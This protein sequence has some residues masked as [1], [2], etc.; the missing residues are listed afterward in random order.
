M[1]LE[2]YWLKMT[3]HHLPISAQL[4]WLIR[5]SVPCSLNL[6]IFIFITSHFY[7]F[8]VFHCHAAFHSALWRSFSLGPLTH[9]FHSALWRSFSTRPFVFHFCHQNHH[10]LIPQTKVIIL[11]SL[12]HCV[13]FWPNGS[14]KLIQINDWLLVK[15]HNLTFPWHT[16]TF[17]EYKDK[18]QEVPRRMS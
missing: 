14:F 13:V 8:C 1:N 4:A 6:N 17:D 12:F 5:R 11:T 18:P 16:F 9:I 10:H 3:M 2:K 15:T 7:Q